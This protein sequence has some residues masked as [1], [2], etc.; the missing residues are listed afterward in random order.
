M[1]YFCFVIIFFLFVFMSCEKDSDIVTPVTQGPYDYPGSQY[2]SDELMFTDIDLN[3]PAVPEINQNWVKENAIPIISLTHNEFDDLMPFKEMF[4]NKKIIQLGECSHGVKEFNQIKTRFI[5]FLHQ[6][7]GFNVLG[8]ESGIFECDYINNHNQKFDSKAMLM[9]SIFAVW[10]TEEVLELF[11]YIKNSYN[12]SNPLMITVFDVQNSTNSTYKN[13]K[14][15]LRDFVTNFDEERAN[16]IFNIEDE[17]EKNLISNKNILIEK[18][19]S[20]LNIYTDMSDYLFQKYSSINNTEEKEK[21]LYVIQI[22]LS[23]LQYLKLYI[24]KSDY[25]S[26]FTLRDIGMANNLE[27]LIDKKYK[28]EKIIVWAHNGHIRHN[29]QNIAHYNAKSMGYY[30]KRKYKNEIFTVGINFYGESGL[31]YILSEQYDGIISS[32]L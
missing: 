27:Y 14:V 26:Y 4:S 31:N 11:K 3:C 20:I 28:N 5:K 8:F 16:I 23:R 29:N 24:K 13:R 6:E 12:S 18:P 15:F 25:E 19:D 9:N 30:L 1:R 10:V 32:I 21:I 7:C 22:C 17:L 2:L